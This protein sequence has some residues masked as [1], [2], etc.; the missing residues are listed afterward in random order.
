MANMSTRTMII[1]AQQ[2][3]YDEMRVEFEAMGTG[4]RYCQQQK[5]Y[6]FKLIDEYGVRAGARILGLPRRMLQRWCREQFKY[7]KR[8]PDWVYSWA[9]RRQKRRAFW[10]R[11]GYC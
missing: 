11:R 5:D 8:C 2:A 9:A 3:I 1:Q 7:V 6:A 10:A 4:S